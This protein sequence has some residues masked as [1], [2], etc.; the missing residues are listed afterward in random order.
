M[1]SKKEI[2]YKFDIIIGSNS[3]IKGDIESEGSIR[4]DGKVIGNV[5]ALGNT[6]ISEDAYI[7]GNITCTNSDIYGVIDGNVSTKGK[8]NLYGKASLT[9]DVIC[10]SFNTEEG[11]HYK[12]NCLVNSK[13]SLEITV[14]PMISEKNMDQLNTNLID[15]KKTQESKSKLDKTQ[16]DDHKPTEENKNNNNNNVKKA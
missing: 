3:I 5:V 10:K 6:I 13:E 11:A 7:H 14:D 8:I 1:F 4:I 2:E 9:G 12:G 15:F 16:A